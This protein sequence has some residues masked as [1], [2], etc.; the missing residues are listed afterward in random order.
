MGA[1]AAAIIIRREK[2]MIAH[3][4]QQ[5]A[6]SVETAQ[7]LD[8]LRIEHNFIFR[9]LEDRAVIRQGANGTYY[10]DELSWSA[11]RRTRIRV[12]LVVVT[13]SVL[14]IGYIAATSAGI[15][16]AKN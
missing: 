7:T 14:L 10:L 5:R 11:I 15:F 12:L 2:D 1:A 8:A 9:R 4:V 6:T 3:F 13:I 16:A